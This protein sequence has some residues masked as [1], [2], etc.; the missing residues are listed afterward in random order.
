MEERKANILRELQEKFDSCKN[1]LGF[2][3]SLD[4]IDS[5]FFIKDAVL[6]VGFVSENFS[7]QLCS[8]MIDTFMSWNGYLNGLL[9]P[10]PSYMAGGMESKL[11]TSEEDKK[12]IWDLIKGSMKLGTTNNLNGLTKDKVEEGK[13]IDEA[14]NY[15]TN[16]FKPKLTKIVGK[17][18]KGWN[19]N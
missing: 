8:R 9:M 14:M 16:D 2:S 17:T 11:F 12:E 18:S 15:W 7:R 5:A 1:E 3:V 6:S 13:F 4:E 19:G 10:N